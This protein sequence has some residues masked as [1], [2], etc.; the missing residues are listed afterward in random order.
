MTNETRSP[1]E[2]ERDIQRER[3]KL[4]DTLEEL[5]S[6][7]SLEGILGKSADQ[8]REHGGDIGMSIARTAKENPIA[9]A[10]TGV[11]LAWM[12]LGDNTRS[13][14][15]RFE[16]DALHRRSPY[17]ASVRVPDWASAADRDERF[18]ESRNQHGE[19][20]DSTASGAHGSSSPSQNTPSGSND[21]F[22]KE[23]IDSA[24]ESMS[25]SFD[26]AKDSLSSLSGR[27]REGTHHF[28]DAARDRVVTAR[29]QAIAAYAKAQ[30]SLQRGKKSGRDLYE[31][32]PLVVGAIAV[33]VGAAL[34]GAMPRTQTEDDALGEMSDSMFAEAERIYEEEFEKARQVVGAVVEEGKKA[35]ADM[36]EN[37]DEEA[38]E[39]KSAVDAVVDKVK[40]TSARISE[41]GKSEAKEQELGSGKASTAKG[42]GSIG[43]RDDQR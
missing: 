6:Q 30:R 20:Q 29:E 32:Q 28:S 18:Y 31:Q 40:E 5:K 3:A 1:E 7:F 8:I 13:G 42:P 34:G 41:A 16:A 37:L 36:R 10:L 22:V 19:R 17:P 24:Q 21:S 15:G 27:V 11:G 26:N 25:E 33:A 39:G 2:I 23:K 38:P 9:L 12:I 43:P 14:R 35:A 4:T